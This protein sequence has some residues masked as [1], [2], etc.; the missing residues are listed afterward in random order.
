[1]AG[2]LDSQ[3]RIIDM[4]LTSR[5][6]LLLSNGELRFVYWAAFDDEVDYHPRITYVASGTGNIDGIFNFIGAISGSWTGSNIGGYYPAPYFFPGTYSGSYKNAT[7]ISQNISGTLTGFLTWEEVQGK[8]NFTGTMTGFVITSGSNTAEQLT[9]TPLTREAVLGYKLLN[10]R[11]EDL[12]NVIRP[13]MSVPAGQDVVPMMTVEANRQIVTFI[14]KQVV[15][16][17]SRVDEFGNQ[18]DVYASTVPMGV[19]R[20]GSN[21]VTVKARYTNQSYPFGDKFEGFYVRVL[22]SAS[23][24]GTLIRNEYGDERPAT[25]VNGQ[26]VTGS[27]PAPMFV[28]RHH[29]LSTGSKIVYGADLQMSWSSPG[30]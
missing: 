18:T 14:Q 3:Q 23:S 15:Q 25:I 29:T 6:K 7:G 30:A 9:E 24:N 12:T 4:V 16:D 11:C 21:D 5:G 20:F 19:K 8:T 13:L 2:F 26:V 17:Y 1:M 28:E 10:N 22:A 27:Y